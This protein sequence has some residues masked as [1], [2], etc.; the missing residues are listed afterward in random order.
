[1][2]NGNEWEVLHGTLIFYVHNNNNT[3]LFRY[4]ACNWFTY[5]VILDYPTPV[6][7]YG[8]IMNDSSI[9]PLKIH[10]IVCVVEFF[11]LSR[12]FHNG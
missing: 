12:L 3:K 6:I 11:R 8:E 1:M 9:K 10:I 5:H 2:R 4:Y 7:D